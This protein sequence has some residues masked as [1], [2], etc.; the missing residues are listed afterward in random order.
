[1]EKQ[2]LPRCFSDKCI[3][4]RVSVTG[5][6]SPGIENRIHYWWDTIK[7]FALV[8]I[9]VIILKV[10]DANDVREGIKNKEFKLEVVLWRYFMILIYPVR[11]NSKTKSD[12]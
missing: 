1:M 12:L 3:C 7:Q 10:P 4:W 11:Y 2:V 6:C 9:R 5:E 8:G